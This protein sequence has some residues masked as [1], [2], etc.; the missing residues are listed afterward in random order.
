MHPNYYQLTELSWLMWS[1]IIKTSKKPACKETFWIYQ[2]W[3]HIY[4]I[5]STNILFISV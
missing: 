5:S 1:A 3:C 4:L 2:V